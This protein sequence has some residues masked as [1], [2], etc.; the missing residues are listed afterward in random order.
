MPV[1][2]ARVIDVAHTLWPLAGAEEWDVPGLIVG[3]PSAE[4][5]AIHLAVDAVADTVAEAVER[6]AQLLLVH[7]PL[8]LRGVTSVAEDRYKGTMVARLIRGGCGL[9]AAHTNADVVAR[10]TS[11][12]LAARLGLVDP[13]PLVPSAR[14]ASLGLGRVGE[15]PAPV[16]LGELARGLG[17]ILPPTAQ[18]IRGAGDYFAPIRRVALCAGAGDSLLANPA[19]QSADVYITSDLRHHPASEAREN[20]RIGGGPALLDI[21]HWAAEWLWLEAAADELRAAL[22]EVTVT[23]SELRTDPWDFALV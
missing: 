22:P 8:L 21:S 2:L 4:V 23:V 3:D 17:E 10:G 11:A 20:A 18:G 5:R 6:D 19:V 14:D 16:T 9:L 13:H 1:A 7:H 15:L 12:V